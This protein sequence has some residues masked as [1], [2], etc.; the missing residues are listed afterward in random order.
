MGLFHPSGFSLDTPSTSSENT[1]PTLQLLHPLSK[2]PLL[3][4]PGTGLSGDLCTNH[5]E[6]ST[7]SYEKAPGA[8][9]A[10]PLQTAVERGEIV[11][12]T[13]LRSD[14][15]GTLG[16]RE[17]CRVSPTSLPLCLGRYLDPVWSHLG[18]CSR[19]FL[20]LVMVQLLQR[21]GVPL[22]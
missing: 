3:S 5:T 18:L 17:V 21:T 20:F 9:G 16:G 1:F 13:F 7:F 8:R 2:H 6:G 19:G 14:I 4:P 12:A 10:L 22:S 11:K 15:D